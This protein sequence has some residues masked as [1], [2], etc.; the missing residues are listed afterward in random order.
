MKP[1]E[2]K[3]RENLAEI[4]R[5]KQELRAKKKIVTAYEHAL[6]NPIYRCSLCRKVIFSFVIE[7]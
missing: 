1:L 3:A 5:L 4:Q 2:A 7:E 6:N